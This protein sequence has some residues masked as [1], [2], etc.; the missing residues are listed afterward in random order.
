[1]VSCVAL[2]SFAA[3]TIADS[4]P[5]KKVADM[6]YLVLSS[7][8]EVYTSK[9]VQRLTKD[10]SVLTASEYYEEDQA[11]PLPAQMFRYGAE[12][13]ADRADGFFYSLLSL[14]PINK[15]NGPGTKLE[16]QGLEYVANNPGENFY[17]NEVFGDQEFFTAIYPDYAVE[18][19]CV[20]CH[21]NHKD[22]PRNDLEVGDVMGAVVIR[23]LVD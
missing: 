12:R 20:D 18:Q 9:V 8:R 23:F 5:Y 21:N 10:D 19:V 2:A 6:L 4:I 14:N 11:L 7:D 16:K 13:V 22:S 15:K 17:S 3:A 1:M